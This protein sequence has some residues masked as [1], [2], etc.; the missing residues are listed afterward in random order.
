MDVMALARQERIEMADFLASLRPEQ[1]V[2]PSLCAGWRI[3]DVAA[4]VVSYEE[5][6][7]G[8]FIR[9][10]TKARFRPARL[11]QVALAEYAAFDP[12]DLVEFLRNHLTPQGATARLGGRVGLV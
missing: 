2:H 9:R 10:V 8:D 6:G 7:G 12:V 4:H 11:N 1:W 3:R 5:H